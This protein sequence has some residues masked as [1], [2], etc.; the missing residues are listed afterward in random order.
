MDIPPRITCY[1]RITNFSCTVQH[2]LE[3]F[4]LL[5]VL[6]LRLNIRPTGLCNY[7]YVRIG[8]TGQSIS[9]FLTD[10]FY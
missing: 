6:A 2:I 5:P 10:M 4:I 1:E 3:G 9:F 7:I 8:F